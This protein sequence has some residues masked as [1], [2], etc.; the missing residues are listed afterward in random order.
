M[1]CLKNYHL[2]FFSR[3]FI[4]QGNLVNPCVILLELLGMTIWLLHRLL[5]SAVRGLSL[6]YQLMLLVS[7]V[8][9]GIWGFLACLLSLKESLSCFLPH[10]PGQMVLYVVCASFPSLSCHWA[11]W[12]S[13]LPLPFAHCILWMSLNLSGKVTVVLIL[14]DFL[15]CE[16]K[17]ARHL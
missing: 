12:R 15:F 4:N 7:A 8:L 5:F 16:E 17:Y 11:C 2:E 10:A 3:K 1:S 13:L 14:F 6:L 9:L